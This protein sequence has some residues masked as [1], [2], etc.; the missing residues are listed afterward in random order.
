MLGHFGDLFLT[1][2]DVAEPAAHAIEKLERV[3]AQ[4]LLT[5]SDCFVTIFAFLLACTCRL[6]E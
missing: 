1:F 3:S 5:G 6:R 4:F 2:I